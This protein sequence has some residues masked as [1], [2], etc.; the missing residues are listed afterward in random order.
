MGMLF[1]L[2]ATTS[3]FKCVMV[4]VSLMLS[5]S[6]PFSLPLGC[7]KSLYGS[8]TTTAVFENL[9]GMLDGVFGIEIRSI[10]VFLE[11]LGMDLDKKGDNVLSYI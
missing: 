10:D 6:I 9:D 3:S 7:R 1:A 8:M 11:F 5:A 4:S 2:A